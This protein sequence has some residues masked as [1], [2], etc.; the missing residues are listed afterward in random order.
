MKVLITGGTGTV[1]KSLVKQ[2][3]NEYISISRNE[4]N[5]ADKDFDDLANEINF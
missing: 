3:N 4:E 2:N 1:G 5:I